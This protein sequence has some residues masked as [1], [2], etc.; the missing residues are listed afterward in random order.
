MTQARGPILNPGTYWID[1]FEREGKPA[2]ADWLARSRGLVR[3]V[4]TVDHRDATPPR[5]WQLFT[6]LFPAPW[7]AADATA[8]G[9]PTVAPHG[10]KTTE[11]DSRDAPDLSPPLDPS[12]LFAGLQGGGGILLLV[13]LLYLLNKGK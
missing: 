1:T 11:A 6:V 5:A 8:F 13:G 3:V 10:E 4:S 9:F 12:N 2:F 7:T